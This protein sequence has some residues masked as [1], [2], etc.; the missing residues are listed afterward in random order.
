MEKT[1]VEKILEEHSASNTARPGQIVDLRVDRLL[2]NDYVGS[3]IFSAMEE[4]GIQKVKEPEKVF[5]AIDHNIPAFTVDAADKYVLFHA[6]A[7]AYGIEAVTNAGDNGIGHQ[8]MMERYVHPLEIALGTDSH[9]TMY[10]GVGAFACGITAADALSVLAT[11]KVWI[12]VP[13][14]IRIVVN[15]R[16]A[17]GVTAKDVSLRILSLL[18]EKECTYRALEIVGEAIDAM[19]VDSRLVLANMAAETGA[20]CAVFESDA[21]AYAFAGREQGRRLRSDAGAHFVKTVEID[22]STLTP[23]LA[24]PNAVTNVQPLETQVGKH[25]DQVFIGSCTNGRMEDLLQACEILKGRHV[26][27][28]TRLLVTPASQ[29]IA[30]EAVKNGVMEILMDAGALILTSSCAS[31]AGNGPGLIGAGERCLSTTNRNFK[32]RM[33]SKTGEVYL[34]SAY[35]A[36][37]AAVVGRITDP[38]QFLREGGEAR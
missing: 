21:K 9:A 8:M 1:L 17:P 33:G 30:R 32:G 12:K 20:K 25:V 3:T 27:E 22:A 13:E 28:G 26:A 24:C 23:L 38:R 5:I 15:G 4:L 29:R 14:T 36:A 37:A 6:K 11:G 34:G 2:M 10:G 16:L 7:R 35:A 19:T 31:C 18:T